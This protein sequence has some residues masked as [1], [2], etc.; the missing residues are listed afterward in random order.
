M[1]SFVKMSIKI[2]FFHNDHID[3]FPSKSDNTVMFLF[4]N[5]V[6]HWHV[7]AVLRMYDL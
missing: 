2:M 3:S 4:Q 6:S 7:C 5:P 1:R